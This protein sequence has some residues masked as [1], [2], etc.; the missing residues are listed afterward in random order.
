MRHRDAA[1]DLERLVVP[2]VAVGVQQPAV[3]V[4]RVLA[5]ADVRHDDELGTRVLERADRLLDDPLVRVALRSGLVL[6]GRDP[7]EQRR[8]DPEQRELACLAGERVHGDLVDPGH[9]RD[10]APDAVAGNDEERVDE[11]VGRK[12]RL[13]HEVAQSRRPAQSPRPLGA[14]GYPQCVDLE[15]RHRESSPPSAAKCDVRA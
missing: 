1:Q 11:V 5:H 7:E 10:R 2:H 4:I 6:R 13:A 3:A 15:L 9:R 8:L 14:R 12:R